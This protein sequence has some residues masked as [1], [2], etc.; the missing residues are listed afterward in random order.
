[1]TILAEQTDFAPAPLLETILDQLLEQRFCMVQDDD[2]NYYVI[3]VIKMDDWYDR[4][5]AD[6]E[7]LHEESWVDRVA[8]ATTNV[9]FPSYAIQR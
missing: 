4:L 8:G 6:D 7:S 2:D 3:P 1:M 9:T 5:Y